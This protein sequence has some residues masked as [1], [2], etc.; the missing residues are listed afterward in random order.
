VIG[1]P[2]PVSESNGSAKER[3]LRFTGERMEMATLV[4]AVPGGWRLRFDDGRECEARI[5]HAAEIYHLKAGERVCVSLG[6]GREPELT[7]F[8]SFDAQAPDDAAELLRR[9]AAGERRFERSGLDEQNF[10]GATL[11]GAVFD[12][13]WLHSSVFRG[14][15]LRGVSFRQ[16]NI[17]CADFRGADLSGASFQ[18]AAVEAAEFEGA[19]LDG[20]SFEGASF[21]G[22][23]IHD[24]DGFPSG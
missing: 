16:C 13:S 5:G 2:A 23:T 17:K 18:E 6:P 9:Y 1:L 11:A 19:R 10:E 8:L 22:Y 15:D 4:E 12:G 14:C 24:G 20:T 7:G 21:Y 3:R